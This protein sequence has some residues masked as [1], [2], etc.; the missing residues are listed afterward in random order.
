MGRLIQ[1]S[2]NK[3]KAE[4]EQKQV[5]RVASA[6]G[7]AA[8]MLLEAHGFNPRRQD[9]SNGQYEFRC[10]F[11]EGP[12]PLERGKATNFYLNARTSEFFC[13]AASC[14]EKGN[15]QL[16]E[17]YFGVEND[18]VASKLY[19]SLDTQLTE[20]QAHL[21]P[22]RRQVFYDKGLR[23]STIDRFRIGYDT[24]AEAYIIPYL[25]ARR[26]LAFRYYD[27]S[28]KNGRPKYW[29]WKSSPN[30]ETST[31]L[32]NPQ[33]AVNPEHETTIVCEGE[34]KAMLLTQVG[35]SAVAVPGANGYKQ[36]WTYHFNHSKYVYVCFDNDNPATHNYDKPEEGRRCHKCE[37][38]GLDVCQGHNPG[39]ECAA[40][41]VEFFGHRSKNIVLP[42]P[43]GMDKTDINEFFMRDGA[44]VNDFH[45]LAFGEEKTSPF[46]VRSL[47]DIRKEPPPETTWL[48]SNLL[49]RAGR[50]LVTGA[51]KVGKSIFIENL[52]LSI[53]A[54]IPFL[55][56]HGTFEPSNFKG[57]R[58]ILLD[59]ELSERSLYDR[60]DALI[61]KSPGYQM[62]EE[63]LLIDHRLQ[64]RLDQADAADKLI[65]LV[66]SNN[67]EVLIFDTAYKFFSGDMEKSSGIAKA[68]QALDEV[69]QE[70]EVSVILTHHH[71]KGSRQPNG[72]EEM[73][74]P[75]QVVG[76]F[77]WTGWPNGTVLLNF[78]DRRVS[79]PFN[80]V[81]SFTAFRD[82]APPDPLALYR[83]KDSI[84]Y[85]SVVPHHFEE[86]E[87]GGRWAEERRILNYENVADMLLQLHPIAED[88]F[89]RKAS[90]AFG[91]KQDSVK[92]KLLDV[93]DRHPDFYRQGDGS[94]SNPYIW[95]YLPDDHPEET[96]EAYA[97][98]QGIELPPAFA[99]VSMFDDEEGLA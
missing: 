22:D 69:I 31:R 65:Q 17:Q 33:A 97:A 8:K 49:P 70:T 43:D 13:Q 74:H 67:A 75:D 95:K 28:R 91:C 4:S 86:D 21:T 76:S 82:C 57:H 39:Q 54:G 23:D 84:A 93:L 64:I 66:R 40:K 85:T 24:D 14:G 25:E 34:L 81:A 94:R 52:A 26:P 2:P 68:F 56:Q 62:A 53:A 10:P 6:D 35:Y 71:R 9:P 45:A 80:T 38:A 60:L 27:P 11:H 59:R 98:Q 55:K 19:K 7:E 92:I 15:L 12:G 89:L 73:P 58:V 46:L 30:E 72:K 48:I 51:P 1:M 16:L 18:P 79:S 5:R 44:N 78:K 37:R 77:L 41:L 96:Y 63:N 61:E 36:E 20:W 90:Q 32:F 99:D 88:D 47:G 29:W 42:R 50:L 83:D 87:E 3:A